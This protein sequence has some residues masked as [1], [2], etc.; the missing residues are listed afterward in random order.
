MGRAA[1]TRCYSH[2]SVLTTPSSTRTKEKIK[3]PS[4]PKCILPQRTT[5]EVFVLGASQ[6]QDGASGALPS[7]QQTSPGCRAQ[8]VPSGPPQ[9]GVSAGRH[10]AGRGSMD[11]PAPTERRAGAEGKRPAGTGCG[12]AA[13]A[14]LLCGAARS[15]PG[16]IRPF[17]ARVRSWHNPA[18]PSPCPARRGGRCCPAR[19]AGCSRGC[20][21]PSSPGRGSPPSRWG[22][23][24]RTPTWPQPAALPRLRA[25]RGGAGMRTAGGAGRLLRASSSRTARLR[26][27]TAARSDGEGCRAVGSEYPCSACMRLAVPQAVPV[28]PCPVLH[29]AAKICPHP[30]D[31]WSHQSGAEGKDHLLA[32]LAS[33]CVTHPIGLPGIKARCWLM[34]R[35]SVTRSLDSWC[36]WPCTVVISVCFVL[37]SFF[38]PLFPPSHLPTAGLIS[39]G[40]I[41]QRR[42]PTG[43]LLWDLQQEKG[44]LRCCRSWSGRDTALMSPTTGAGCQSTRQQLTIPANVWG[45]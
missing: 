27:G 23:R 11:R 6:R 16:H 1:A 26:G 35:L 24:S 29:R 42:I 10:L 38:S 13:T 9:S 33:L 12:S 15:C 14:T 5:P 34:A 45:C 2:S 7:Y 43:V 32:L 25:G 36:F 21:P 40:W 41:S 39:K 19:T 44:M 8:P 4:I 18:D 22:S 17:R 28:A 20:A 30:L 37:T 31:S 3:T